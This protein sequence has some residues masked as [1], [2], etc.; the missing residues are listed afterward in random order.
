MSGLGQDLRHATRGLTRSP[1]FTIVAVLTLALGIGANVAIFTLVNAVLLRPLPFDD[2][3]RLVMLSESHLQTGQQ[4]VGV[5]PGSF[6]D[7]RDRSRSFDAM[8][9]FSTH[10]TLI[11]NRQEPTRIAG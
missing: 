6:F 9:L 8:S 3:D 10:P 5:L 4:R 7:W 2:S 11:T 1:G